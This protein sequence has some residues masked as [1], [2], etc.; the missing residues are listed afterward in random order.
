MKYFILFLSL[1]GFS[2]LYAQD[3][4]TPTLSPFAELSQEV[5]L[6]EISLSYARPSAKG[7]TIFGDLVPYGEVWRTGANASTKLT[8]SEAVTVAGNSLPA[9][10][11][12]LY[13][14]PGPTEWTI[15][16]HK[17][18]GM[19]SIA[20]D[21]VKPENDAFRFTV[22]PIYNPLM[23]E[24]F[25]IQFTDISTNSLQLQLSW[26]H[27]IVRF[28]IEVEV[29]AK[30]AAQMAD[31]EAEAAGVSDRALFRAAEY[32]LHNQR[33]L[34]Q[35]MTWIDAALAKSENNFRYG[36]LKAKIYAAMGMAEQ[37]VATVREANEWAT[38]AGNA[39]YMEQTAVYLASLEN[40]PEEASENSPYA[41]DVSSL[42]HILAALYDV[43]SGE[44]GEARDWDRF[45]HLFIAD[46]QL[47]P[48]RPRADGRIGYSVLSPTDY[49]NNAGA[50]LVENGF[51][52]KEI[53]RSVEEYGSLVHAFSTY[54]SYRSEADEAPFARGINS[55]QLLNDGQRW[56]VVSIYWLGE[57]EA[58]PLP[59]RYLPK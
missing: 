35:A 48:S 22:R 27:T 5:G 41:E 7:R 1:C 28:P 3:L 12:A 40:G 50:W 29:D 20:G 16:V 6:T 21:A 51:F 9:G 10:T 11:Y 43:I 30:I 23:V 4:R 46:A 18:T 59:E 19:R 44:A 58:W 25:T 56:W 55:I 57:S 2:F 13:T 36:L 49:A 42:D 53:H 24:T 47:M 32:N 54:E 26:E 39:N 17:N 8:V 33:D 45:N 34:N 37:A 38:A 31:M 15:I 52:E 14:I